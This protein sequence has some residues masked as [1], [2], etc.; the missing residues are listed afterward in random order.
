MYFLK[1]LKILNLIAGLLPRGLD[2]ASL[3]GEFPAPG[4]SSAPSLHASSGEDSLQAQGL[5]ALKV[6]LAQPR[7]L[8]A[9][10]FQPHLSE[11]SSILT[12][13]QLR[14]QPAEQSRMLQGQLQ[15]PVT[16]NASIAFIFDHRVA[17]L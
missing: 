11:P 4:I 10:A 3:P 14:E 6:A 17:S 13:V 9:E 8:V 5:V 15:A 16:L 12:D 2:A 7:H 1:I